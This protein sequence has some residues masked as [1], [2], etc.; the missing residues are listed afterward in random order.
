MQTEQIL[1]LKAFFKQKADFLTL[2]DAP[3]HDYSSL[4]TKI[5]SNEFQDEFVY[6]HNL[7]E[8]DPENFEKKFIDRCK[9]RAQH[10]SGTCLSFFASPDNECNQL[11]WQIAEYLF[12]PKTMSEMFKILLADDAVFITPDFYLDIPKIA[13]PEEIIEASKNPALRLIET[14][15]SLLNEFPDEEPSDDGVLKLE[16]LKQF[17]MVDNYLV[18]VNSIAEFRFVHHQTLLKTLQTEKPALAEKLY[19]HNDALQILYKNLLIV[20]N[21]GQ[22]PYEAIKRLTQEL[23]SGGSRLTG[24]ENASIAAQVAY[25]EF[26]SYLHSLPQSL[27]NQLMVLQTSKGKPFSSILNHLDNGN[28]VEQASDDLNSI[29]ENPVN[30]SV[31][32]TRPNLTQEQIDTIINQYDKKILL[33]T[34]NDSVQT[35]PDEYLTKHLTRIQINDVADYYSFLINFP[36]N[37]YDSLL[38]HAQIICKPSLPEELLETLVA[39][40]LSETQLLAFNEAVKHNAK[41]LGL[42]TGLEYALSFKDY[43]LFNSILS[44]FTQEEFFELHQSNKALFLKILDESPTRTIILSRWPDA[45]KPLSNLEMRYLLEEAAFHGSELEALLDSIL[46]ED[47]LEIITTKNSRGETLLHSV[48]NPRAR[49]IILNRL[50][51]NERVTAILTQD[52]KGNNPLSSLRIDNAIEIL[53]L[54]PQEERL[55]IIEASKLLP[56]KT[57]FSTISILKIL[58]AQDS[59]TLVNRHNLL[60]GRDATNLVS[61]LETIP[62]ITRSDIIKKNNLLF[63]QNITTVVEILETLP[64]QDRLEAVVSKNKYGFSVFDQTLQNKGLKLILEVLPVQDRWSAITCSNNISNCFDYPEVL[65][66]LLPYLP[67]E[68]RLNAVTCIN[69]KGLSLLD[70]LCAEYLEDLL[71]LLPENDRFSVIQYRSKGSDY[72]ILS[73]FKNPHALKVVLSLLPSERRAEALCLNGTLNYRVIDMIERDNLVIVLDTLPWEKRLEVL[74]SKNQHG[75]FPLSKIDSRLLLPLQKILSKDDWIKMV[76]EGNGEA[77]SLYWMVKEYLKTNQQTNA[78]TAIEM[79][80]KTLPKDNVTSL[81]TAETLFGNSVLHLV[82]T[83]PPLLSY[84]LDSISPEKELSFIQSNITQNPSVMDLLLT[85]S[86]SLLMILAK[87]PEM[88][89]FPSKDEVYLPIIAVYQQIDLLKNHGCKLAYQSTYNDID[90]T[91]GKKAVQLAEQLADLM[92][93]FVHAKN[94][95]DSNQLTSI[96]NQFACALEAGHRE[97]KTHRYIWEPILANIA[98]AATGIGLLLIIGKYLITGSTFFA[99]T[100][101]QKMVVSIEEKFNSLP[102]A[103]LN[104]R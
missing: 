104:R 35:F 16:R 20:N 102:I 17:T 27:K 43:N 32:K 79:I 50:P 38:K 49:R 66:R 93:K 55:N 21:Q 101:R 68:Q 18:D 44:F 46:L 98:I 15:L 7:L 53:K 65:F 82:A 73:L 84:I 71:K 94:S 41:K 99:A 74:Q 39:G 13:S 3:P 4:K 36:P 37:Y 96:R 34:G 103:E 5:I 85:N 25:T 23:I 26:L 57:I 67:E 2:D 9:L 69:N 42:A 78:F 56:T 10:N 95:S 63:N 64:S 91:E 86:E 28:C 97:M 59:L 19:H 61:I 1:S 48:S 77:N 47:R 6:L 12:Q 87:L 33:T 80:L 45:E 14:P 81:L 72:P 54:L 30:K 8:N 31:L 52:T 70:S 83:V 88:P 76:N 40:I 22:T 75:K 90:R 29:L 51:A 24:Q 100:N 58:P 92:A 11:Y 62:A 60:S 89:S